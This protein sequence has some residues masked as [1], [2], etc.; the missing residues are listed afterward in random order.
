MRVTPPPLLRTA[1][2]FI[3]ALRTA[4]RH[5]LTSRTAYRLTTKN[6]HFGRFHLHKE[7]SV[8]RLISIVT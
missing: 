3:L 2:R 5:I 4:Y 8:Q 7:V 6:N 1:Y